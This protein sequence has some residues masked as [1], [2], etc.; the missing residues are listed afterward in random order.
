VNPF[1]TAT[2][3]MAA[4]REHKILAVE[5]LDLHIKRIEEHDS[6]LNA[7]V[8]RDFDRARETARRAD[9]ARSR[10]EDAP[11][12]GIPMTVKESFHVD[13][14]E[15]CVGIPEHRGWKADGNALAIQRLLDAGVEI[16]GK[17]NI[18]M[19]LADWISDNP[20]YGRTNNPW[21]LSRSPGGSSGG[22]SAAVAAG[23]SPLEL[24]SDIGGSVRVPAN[25]CG[26]Y[27]HRPSDSALPRTGQSPNRPRLPNPTVWMAVQGPLA[28][29]AEDLELMFDVLSGPDTGEDV[30]WKL[31]IPQAR[32]ETL[33]GFRVAVMPAIPWLPVD[34]EILV[35]QEQVL[36]VLT[37]AGATVSVTQPELFGDLQDFFGLYFRIL[38]TT[39][40]GG[41]TPQ[42]RADAA[43]A[44]RQ[45][46][47]MT[48]EATANAMMATA[49][50]YREWFT[51]REFYRESLRAFYRDW[52]ILLCPAFNALAIPHQDFNVPNADR[53]FT[54]AGVEFP[55]EQMIT[56]PAVATLPGQPATAFPT[57]ISK[58][59]LPLGLQA[60]GPYL[61]DRTPMRFA[62]LLAHEIGGFQPP[63][64]Y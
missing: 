56:Y 39:M 9:E 63:P 60:I 53:T 4:L 8:I 22:S 58:K 20:V 31:E 14:L 28:R 64:G 44:A 40:S 1:S 30:A 41:L 18:P 52:D 57:G 36:G 24:G 10:G 5:L 29:C 38:T 59:G 17:T 49:F 23:L 50:E 45:R 47:G 15:T 42:Q 35:A 21:D 48:G 11:L 46:G 6:K 13:G 16:M 19:W 26:V 25:F 27:G 43:E 32:H 51:R 37:R 33:A 34:E 55:Y 62:S 12:L 54:V 3:M 2:E 7:V 61:E